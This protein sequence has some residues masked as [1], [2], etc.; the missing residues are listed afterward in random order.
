MFAIP[1]MEY[2]QHALFPTHNTSQGG[3]NGGW[4]RVETPQ[5]GFVELL[6]RG[7]TRWHLV[8][9]ELHGSCQPRE[10]KEDFCCRTSKHGKIIDIHFHPKGYLR[11]NTGLTYLQGTTPPTECDVCLEPFKLHLHVTS[12][13]S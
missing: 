10:K 9:D 7:G 3:L 12:G 11:C 1:W 4:S 8:A 2:S 5:P 6:A 13:I